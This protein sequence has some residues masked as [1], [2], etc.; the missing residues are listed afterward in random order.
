M[1]NAT[2]MVGGVFG[3]LNGFAPGC[4]ITLTYKRLQLYSS[5]EYVFSVQNRGSNFFYIWDQITF[6]PLHWLQVGLVS[7]RTR[8]YQTGLDVQRG[9]L[10]GVTYK[11]VNFTTNVFNFWWTTPPEVLA[12]GFNF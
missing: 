5:A 12:L 7:Q 1:L 2:P 4:A 6:S 3:N 8:V 9:V 11:K 10:A